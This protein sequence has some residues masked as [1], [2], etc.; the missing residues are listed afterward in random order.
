MMRLFLLDHRGLIVFQTILIIIILGIIWLAGF[1]DYTILAYA[2]FMYLILFGCF[3]IYKYISRRSFYQILS[4]PLKGIGDSLRRL[5]YAPISLS[6]SKLLKQQYEF[7]QEENL[8]LQK[9]QEEQLIFIDRWVHQMKTPISVLELIAKELDEPDSSNIREEIDRLQAGLSTIMY[10]SKLRTIEEDFHIEKVHLLRLFEEIQK[11]NRR[12]FIRNKV[13]PKLMR[14][15]GF[16]VESDE[17]WLFFI[18]NQII[19]NAIKYTD[20]RSHE[21]HFS[22]YQEKGKGIFE[23]KDFGVG[24]PQTDLK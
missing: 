2:F 15:E 3:L 5:D 10:M 16:T 23:I 24:I 11:E 4:G 21:I 6:L 12:L 13:Y 19:S 22:I 18:I 17:K 8:N 14:Q 7:F 1:R 9:R 20:G